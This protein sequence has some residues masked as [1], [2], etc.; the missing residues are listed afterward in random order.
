MRLHAC[1]NGLFKDHPAG[2]ILRG[3]FFCLLYPLHCQ[4]FTVKR[5][6]YNIALFLADE[7]ENIFSH[8]TH[9]YTQHQGAD[10]RHTT[11]TS[12]VGVMEVCRQ[13]RGHEEKNNRE[14]S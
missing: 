5:L 2:L 7:Q 13:S 8:L 1:V 9:A 14:A 11:V 12:S 6:K 4:N 3:L 10:I